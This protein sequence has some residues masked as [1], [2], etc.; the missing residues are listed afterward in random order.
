M[1]DLA[2]TNSLD[3]DPVILSTFEIKN[4]IQSSTKAANQQ[5]YG[6]SYKIRLTE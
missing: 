5:S 1:E 2:A 6:S 4:E 3:N